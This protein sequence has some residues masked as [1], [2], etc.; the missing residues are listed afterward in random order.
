MNGVVFQTSV[1]MI[2]RNAD[3]LSQ[4]QAWSVSSRPL[5]NPVVGSN[6]ELPGQ[7]GDDGDDPVGHEHRGPHDRTAEDRPVHHAGQREAEHELDRHRDHG[8]D[9]RARDGPPP[10]R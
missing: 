1:A 5:T 7:G 10:L 4:N 8:H 2:T 3:Q 6:G 9:Q